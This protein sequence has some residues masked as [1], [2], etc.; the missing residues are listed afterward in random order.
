M[1]G[2]N[3]KASPDLKISLTLCWQI[4]VCGV[5][6]KTIRDLQRAE[7]LELRLPQLKLLQVQD[8]DY[9]KR[10]TYD[11]EG[12]KE[13][14]EF[15]I[16]A[17]PHWNTDLVGLFEDLLEALEIQAAEEARKQAELQEWELI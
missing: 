2:F 7:F 1:P 13:M 9:N 5:T 11:E 14:R 4:Q 10:T 6:D 15:L 12:A 17:R 3:L 8:K 16:D